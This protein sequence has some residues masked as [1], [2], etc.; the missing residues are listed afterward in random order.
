L[1]DTQPWWL[2]PNLLALDAPA[3]AVAWQ[4]FLAAKAAVAVPPAAAIVLALVVWGVYLTDR[5]IDAATGATN[6]DRHRFASRHPIAQAAFGCA[7]LFAA[8]ALALFTLP[9]DYL[10]V[11]AAVAAGTAAYLVAVHVGRRVLGPGMKEL[12][13]GVVFAAGAAVPL[14]ADGGPLSDWLPGVIA[15]AGLCWL[16]CALIARWE[17]PATAPPRWA[18]AVSGSLTLAAL[19]A[20]WDVAVAVA[21]S[22]AGLA[23]L[24]AGRAVVPVRAKRV[25]A[26]I[27]LLSPLAVGVLS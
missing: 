25:L 16:N 22:A 8:G 11:G 10:E 26:D 7:V 24:H 2:W 12:S 15:F 27:A 6:S 19:A 23:A 3:V 14:A 13:V 9:H 1:N 5:A 20:P 4:L 18:L 21:L 17:E